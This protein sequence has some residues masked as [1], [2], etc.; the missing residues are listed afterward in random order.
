ML[1]SSVKFFMPILFVYEICLSLDVKKS[2]FSQVALCKLSWKWEHPS[3]RP[4]NPSLSYC[5]GWPPRPYNRSFGGP[6]TQEL[7]HLSSSR[8]RLTEWQRNTKSRSFHLSQHETSSVEQFSCQRSPGTRLDLS[9]TETTSSISFLPSP[10]STLLSLPFQRVP[11][12]KE[13]PQESLS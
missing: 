8:E 6:L 3:P 5:E 10:R 7:Y 1:G 12:S 11:H 2:V 13:L 9:P 4:L